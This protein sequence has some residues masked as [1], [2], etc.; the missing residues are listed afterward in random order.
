MKHEYYAVQCIN[1]IAVI[2]WLPLLSLQTN[3]ISHKN[4]GDEAWESK[5]SLAILSSHNPHVA[6]DDTA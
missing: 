2:C 6:N 5:A 4:E 1:R 3:P